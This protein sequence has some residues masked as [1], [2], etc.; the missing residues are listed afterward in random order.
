MHLAFKAVFFII[1]I[2]DCT[3][4]KITDSRVSPS[5]NDSVT[6]ICTTDTSW[7]FCTWSRDDG[8]KCVLEWKRAKVSKVTKET[9]TSII[10][11]LFQLVDIYM[12]LA[13]NMDKHQKV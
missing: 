4:F 10:C 13:Y 12:E 7:E 3:S 2:R 11:L 6:M 8:V 9:Q 5:V 1:C